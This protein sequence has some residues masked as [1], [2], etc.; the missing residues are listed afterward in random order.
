M[1]TGPNCKFLA[2]GFL[3]INFSKTH[4]SENCHK[5]SLLEGFRNVRDG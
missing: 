5:D 3:D 2:Q 4:Y 1:R